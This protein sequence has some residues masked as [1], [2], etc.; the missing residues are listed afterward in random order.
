MKKL[1]ATLSPRVVFTALR[2]AAIAAGVIGTLL[3]AWLLSL[4]H[5]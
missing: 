3:A 5:I 4:I 1:E 2:V